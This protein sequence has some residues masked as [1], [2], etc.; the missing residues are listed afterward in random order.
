M[1]KSQSEPTRHPAQKY[2]ILTQPSRKPLPTLTESP[3]RPPQWEGLG[4]LSRRGCIWLIRPIR[5]VRLGETA[6]ANPLAVK[7]LAKGR[8]LHCKTRPFTLSFA[9]FCNAKCGLS[10]GASWPFAAHPQFRCI[11]CKAQSAN[12]LL[13]ARRSA[14]VMPHSD[15]ASRKHTGHQSVQ[16]AYTGCRIGVR[17]DNYR[18]P[19]L[20]KDVSR[21]YS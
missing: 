5:P 6:L 2:P 4:M 14:T 21:Q 19:G 8:V 12:I 3:S 7:E 11:D 15:A 10:H 17:H 16:A 20:R 13:R 9:A 1:K 18:P